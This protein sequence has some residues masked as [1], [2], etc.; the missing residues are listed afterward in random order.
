MSVRRLDKNGDWTFGV[1]RGNYITGGDAI[2]QKVVTRLKSFK[3]DNPLN[4]NSNIDWIDLLSRKDTENDIL[5]EVE[6]VVLQTDGVIK[7]NSVEVDKTINRSQT[8]LLSYDTI[9][10]ENNSVGVSD[11]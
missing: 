10:S 7:V 9:Y 3:N 11:L 8:V 5:K 1:G 6:R 4:M 2:N